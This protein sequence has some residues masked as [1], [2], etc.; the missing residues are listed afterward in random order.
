MADFRHSGRKSRE[1]LC[2]TLYLPS[3]V[4]RALIDRPSGT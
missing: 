1:S 2:Q 3:C 4:F